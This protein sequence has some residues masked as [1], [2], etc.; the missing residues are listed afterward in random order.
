MAETRTASGTV[1]Q[2]SPLLVVADG[3][4]TACPAEL[5]VDTAL[6]VGARVQLQDRSP[7]RPLLSAVS[8]PDDE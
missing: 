7:R 8:E 5:G 3:A 6:T 1:T 2:V 4:V